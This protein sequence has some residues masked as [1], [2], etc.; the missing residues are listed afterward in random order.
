MPTF[1]HFDFD[2]DE[3]EGRKEKDEHVS[4]EHG[5]DFRQECSDQ[6]VPV[7]PQTDFSLSFPLALGYQLPRF[8]VGCC[9]CPH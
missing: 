5:E 1:D 4:E 8:V 3:Q 6:W 9:A 2:D 7:Y